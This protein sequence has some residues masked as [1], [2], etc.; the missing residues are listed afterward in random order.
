MRHIAC[1]TLLILAVP[2][3]AQDPSFA[4]TQAAQQASQQATMASQQA[5]AQAMQASQQAN[6]NAQQAAAMA[7]SQNDF[8]SR[9]LPRPK[10]SVKSGSYAS[11]QTVTLT[12]SARGATIYY[13]TDGW[14]PTPLSKQYDGPFTIAQ[15][16]HLQAIAVVPYEGRS[17]IADS[18]LTLPSAPGQAATPV[19]VASKGLLLQGTTLSLSFGA[20][21]DSSTAKVGDKVPL[22]L[23]SDIRLG[24]QSIDTSHTSAQA[25]VIHVDRKATLGRPG[26]LTVRV[27]SLTLNGV[28]VPLSGIET[29]EGK[30]HMG[31]VMSTMWIPGI[32]VASAAEHGESVE[33][34]PGTAITAH[35]AADTRI[36]PGSATVAS[37]VLPAS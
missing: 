24:S 8:G 6:M 33:I 32:G 1:L 37:G 35:V 12:D 22:R 29:L 23:T 15:T 10:I 26:I 9:L 11:P 13:T 17:F 21:V 4:A 14:T 36:M 3:F 18:E 16:T 34:N 30:S 31:R 27:D 28:V 2:V 5:N 25:T 20:N 7:S 19:I